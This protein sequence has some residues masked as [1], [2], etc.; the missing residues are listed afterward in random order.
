ME[1]EVVVM[2]LHNRWA[3]DGGKAKSGDDGG[4]CDDDIDEEGRKRGHVHDEMMR[5]MQYQ[6][7]QC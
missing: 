6:H 4:E 2:R 1:R 7:D 3:G 5:R